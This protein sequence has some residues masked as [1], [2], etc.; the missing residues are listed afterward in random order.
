M[1][2]ALD[3]ETVALTLITGESSSITQ[4]GREPY[5]CLTPPSQTLAAARWPTVASS[6]PVSLC[7]VQ[8]PHPGEHPS[9]RCINTGAE[10]P[11]LTQGLLRPSYD[12]RKVCSRK[13]NSLPGPE[14]GCDSQRDQILPLYAFPYPDASPWKTCSI[15]GRRTIYVI[16]KLECF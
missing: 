2:I 16:I 9:A 14:L 3:N 4:V 13:M 10:C 7:S 11:P 6:S 5:S 12:L 1:A 15:P 8:M